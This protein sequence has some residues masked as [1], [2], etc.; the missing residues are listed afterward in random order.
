MEKVKFRDY[1]KYPKGI[2]DACNFRD[3][4][5][6]EPDGAFFA[7]ARERGLYDALEEMA[8]WENE[9]TTQSLLP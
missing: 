3:E 5:D 2:M 7:I 6:D 1:K 8:I 4:Y 9:N